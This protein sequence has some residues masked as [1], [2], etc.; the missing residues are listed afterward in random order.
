MRRTLKE[1]V[2]VSPPIS[3]SDDTITCE[4]KSREVVFAGCKVLSEREKE[5]CSV[6]VHETDECIPTAETVLCEEEGMAGR[7]DTCYVTE[8]R[9]YARVCYKH[10]LRQSY[11]HWCVQPNPT[12]DRSPG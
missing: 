11:N 8:D 9:D 10:Y 1:R 4:A 3:P 12:Y 5:G 2:C 6:W 7:E